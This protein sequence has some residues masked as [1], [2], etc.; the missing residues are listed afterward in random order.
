MPTDPQ[1]KH[2]PCPGHAPCRSHSTGIATHN[3]EVLPDGSLAWHL[4]VPGV[5][6]PCPPEPDGPPR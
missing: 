5:G 3:A 4:T 2:A 6:A 1:R